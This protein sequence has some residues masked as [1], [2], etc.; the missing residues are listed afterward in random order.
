MSRETPVFIF[1]MTMSDSSKCDCHVCQSSFLAETYRNLKE[2]EVT[3]LISVDIAFA[4]LEML[5]Y[6]ESNHFPAPQV[7][8]TFL[9]E[10]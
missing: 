1:L 5:T 3:Y 2:N 8:A 9:I 7:P 6:V 4:F 10:F